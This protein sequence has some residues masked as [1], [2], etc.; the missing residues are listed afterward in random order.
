MQKRSFFVKILEQ[1]QKSVKNRIAA[2][3]IDI[4]RSVDS[5]AE[6]DDLICDMNHI[7]E[8]IVTSAG[9]PSEKYSN[10]YTADRRHQ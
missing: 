4:R 1:P 3:K 9:C 2:G 7:I 8:G 5:A 6:L 10:A